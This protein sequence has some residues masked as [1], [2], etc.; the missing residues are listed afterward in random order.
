MVARTVKAK[1]KARKVAVSKSSARALAASL[2]GALSLWLVDNGNQLGAVASGLLSVLV[3]LA[4]KYFD[5]TEKA[6]GRTE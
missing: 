1:A 6:F 5:P 3:P 2:L 4:I